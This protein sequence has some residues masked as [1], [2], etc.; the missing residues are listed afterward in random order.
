[1]STYKDRFPQYHKYLGNVDVRDLAPRTPGMCL[2]NLNGEKAGFIVSRLWNKFTVGTIIGEKYNILYAP[3]ADEV[4]AGW[5]EWATTS[6]ET[7][8]VSFSTRKL[9]ISTGYVGVYG[10]PDL[11]KPPATMSFTTSYSLTSMMWHMSYDFL[12]AENLTEKSIKHLIKDV[13]S[14]AFPLVRKFFKA[15]NHLL[16]KPELCSH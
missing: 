3:G 6:D 11:P 10:S 15:N 4:M 1:M 9:H 7:H 8:I 2:R 13:P 16:Y 14:T 12:D 5:P